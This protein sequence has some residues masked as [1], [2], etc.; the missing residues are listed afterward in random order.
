MG[1]KHALS[2]AEKGKEI[3]QWHGKRHILPPVMPC[4]VAGQFSA[5]RLCPLPKADAWS[6]YFVDL[7]V[8]FGVFG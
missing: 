1:G 2:E 5:F 7:F 3:G 6:A 8:F 4:H